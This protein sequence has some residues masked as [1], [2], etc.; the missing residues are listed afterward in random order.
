VLVAHVPSQARRVDALRGALD[1]QADVQ[2]RLRELASQSESRALSR[3]PRVYVTSFRL[4][5]F[6]SYFG[7]R[8]PARVVLPRGVP[9]RGAFVTPT[10]A[11]PGAPVDDP[12]LML[13]Q[14]RPPGAFETVAENRT[15][16]LMARGCQARAR[17]SV[18]AGAGGGVGRSP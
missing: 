16:S 4:I 2:D 9:S 3:C 10:P 15:W 13:V 8:S 5:P 18:V 1:R 14:A 12:A 6:I 7:E 11:P 17:R